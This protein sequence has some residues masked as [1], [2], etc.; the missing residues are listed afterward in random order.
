MVEGYILHIFNLSIVI[1]PV[2][3]KNFQIMKDAVMLLLFMSF[4]FGAMYLYAYLEAKSD[5]KRK[6]S[7]AGKS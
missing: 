3:A 5:E 1:G 4:F 6:N 2:T 7:R